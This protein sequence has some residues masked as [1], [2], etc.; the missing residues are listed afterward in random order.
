MSAHDEIKSTQLALKEL[1]ASHSLSE[2]LLKRANQMLQRIERPVRLGVFGLPGSGKSTLI[3]LLL[4]ADVLP[5]DRSLPTIS[6]TYG[7]T[8]QAVCTMQDGKLQLVEGDS[9]ADLLDLE[10]AFIEAQLPLPALS[11]LSM[12][13]LVAGA[14]PQEQQKA[15]KW[16]AK[17]VDLAVWCSAEAFSEEEQ[18]IWDFIPEQVQDHS[19][20]LL[21]NVDNPNKRSDPARRLSEASDNGRDYFKQVLP[22]ATKTALTARSANGAVD[23]EVMRKAGAMNLISAILR[24]VEI[25]AQS[26]LDQAEVFLRQVDFTPLSAAEAVENPAEKQAQ[27]TV[28]ATPEPTETAPVDQPEPDMQPEPECAPE[29]SDAEARS[30]DVAAPEILTLNAHSKMIVG[31]AVDQL[32]AE[33]EVLM[34]SLAEDQLSEETVIET[35]AD[36]VSWLADYMSESESDDD[37][38]YE[39][40][41]DVALDAADLAQLIQLETSGTVASDMLTLMVQLRQDMQTSLA[42]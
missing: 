1:I 21:T 35:C 3:N 5:T 40:C 33:G 41:R 42:A 10:P 15:T 7:E 12:L 17:R 36:T 9:L 4:G 30:E 25:G 13:E 23:K 27:E 29:P 22:I 31:Q 37:P 39:A 26:A 34:Q 11:K 14:K 32:V 2:P 28:A 6:L 8:A 16:A 38:A 24:E 19:F 18:D 20:L